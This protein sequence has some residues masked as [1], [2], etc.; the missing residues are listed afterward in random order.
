MKPI[1]EKVC[2]FLASETRPTVAEYA[3]VFGLIT[4]VCL[5]AIR[6]FQ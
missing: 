3:V 5:T 2:G 4:I 1:I 6:A